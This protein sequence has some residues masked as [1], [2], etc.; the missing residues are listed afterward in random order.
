[1]PFWFR[2]V[3]LLCGIVATVMD[4]NDLRQPPTRE[5]WR[6]IWVLFAFAIIVVG[7]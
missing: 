2:L 4:L 3:M 5:I 1:M 6:V 7:L